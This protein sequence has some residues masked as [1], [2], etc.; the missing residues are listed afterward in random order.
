MMLWIALAWGHGGED[1]GPPQAP[2]SAL[3]EG[4]SLSTWSTEYEA[5]VRLPYA[6]PGQPIHG[7]ALVA[8]WRTS[9]PVESGSVAITW[10]GPAK[11]E[12]PA[13][14]P[15]QAGVFEFSATFPTHGDYVGGL[16]V[17]ADRAD[18][19]GL[20]AFHY[21]L[22]VGPTLASDGWGTGWIV[23]GVVG[24]LGLG[25][26]L[27]V[28]L[29]FGTGRWSRKLAPVV[30]GGLGLGISVDRLQAH[31]GEDH[32]APAAPAPVGAAPGMLSMALESQ[33]LLGVRTDVVRE[34]EF[35]DSVRILGQSVVRPGGGAEIAA[36]VGGTL[37]LAPNLRPGMTV[38]AGQVLGTLREG[39]SG[40]ER[41]GM[42]A[43]ET[44]A[45]VELARARKALELAERDAARAETLGS[46]LS[47]R[48][49]LDRE[50]SVEVARAAVH[51][52]EIAA[53]G[54]GST[55][56][57]RAPVSGTLASLD[58]RTGQV[59]AAS[60][61]LFTIVS[62]GVLWVEAHVPEAYAG[63]IPMGAEATLRPV[64]GGD[65][66][67][68]IVLDPGMK[69][70]PESGMLHLT[71]ELAQETPGIVPGMKIR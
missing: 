20:P 38:R 18:V 71:L 57:L 27:G 2:L 55:L 49:R 69:A 51:Q 45:R 46:A 5:V 6:D 48:E 32:G 22:P 67:T 62:G 29:G 70:D 12:V 37:E 11:V 52:A 31:G 47:E 34:A 15:K 8:D 10:D 3:H 36:P 21:A 17:I 66:L 4:D 60:D 33:F 39:L 54:S 50:R 65:A 59:V 25:V 9:A 19:L 13:L 26:L 40:A 56:T 16:T 53:E 64:G 42:V 61:P 14:S 63:K 35:Q 1:H 24:G 7:R 23:G 28:L 41:S 68:A 58:A 43:A 30:L 44:G